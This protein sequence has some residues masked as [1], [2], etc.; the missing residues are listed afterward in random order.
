M[1]N[2]LPVTRILVADDDSDARAIVAIGVSALGFEVMEARDGTEALQVFTDRHPDLAVL[3]MNMPG[4]TGS[5]VC[6]AIKE[7]ESGALIPVLILTANETVRDK[8]SA[9]EGGVDDYLTKPFH[10][11]ELQARI[12]ALLRV[13]ELN[14][15]L[16]E[17]NKEL[18]AMQEKLVQHERQVVVSQ[19]AG[20]AAHQ[21]GQPLSAIMLN[22]HLLERLPSTDE[23][24]Q[25]ALHAVKADAKRM[26]ELIERLRGVDA[27]K[28]EAYHGEA[29][30][31]NLEKPEPATAQA[32][33]AQKS[34]GQK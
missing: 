3:D 10:L 28:T 2:D 7:S 32:P 5:E 29:R 16:A 13:R 30:I 1:T 33:S 22:C 15:R 21:L 25:K 9:F 18:V 26:A 31:L 23:R 19:L 34:S 4:L 17:K 6:K 8:V 12:K 14:V 20:T 24:F 11:E 27:K